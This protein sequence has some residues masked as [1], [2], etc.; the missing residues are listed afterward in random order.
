[1]DVQLVY[2]IINMYNT[3]VY[4]SVMYIMMQKL[5]G[6]QQQVHCTWRQTD[7]VI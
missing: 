1:M 5:L 4:M 7:Q 2:T 3:S 6:L